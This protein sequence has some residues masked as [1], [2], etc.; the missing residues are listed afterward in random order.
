MQGLKFTTL[1]KD[2][3]ESPY[4]WINIELNADMVGK[5]RVIFEKNRFVIC[6]IT[7]F[8]EFQRRGIAK[9]AINHFKKEHKI[10]IADRVRASAV[11][12]WVAMGFQDD[13]DGNYSLRQV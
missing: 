6:S 11:A 10:L 5:A 12:F 9:E 4:T 1:P 13:G 8:P 7:V 3:P 2:R